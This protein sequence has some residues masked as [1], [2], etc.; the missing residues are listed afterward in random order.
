MNRPCLVLLAQRPHQTIIK[1]TEGEFLECPRWTE[2]LANQKLFFY[3]SLCLLS[4]GLYC[5][6]W[7]L[8]FRLSCGP[9]YHTHK[10]DISSTVEN[11]FSDS[12]TSDFST[13]SSPT[14]AFFPTTFSIN[15]TVKDGLQCCDPSPL[16]FSYIWL[17]P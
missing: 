13:S 3:T 9:S 11:L 6:V 1:G 4:Y 2:K 12:S 15:Y 7:A 10:Y 14:P 17:Y 5:F 8:L 16:Y